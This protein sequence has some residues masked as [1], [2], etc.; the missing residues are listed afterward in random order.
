MRT[1][2]GRP[3]AR[4]STP[5]SRPPRSAIHAYDAW[6]GSIARPGPGDATLIIWDS[7]QSN[8]PTRTVHLDHLGDFTTTLRVVPIAGLAVC[9]GVF[10]AFVAAALLKLIGL[11]TNVFFFQRLDTSLVSPTG[12]HLGP[13]VVL[14]PVAG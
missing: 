7:M 14:V 11:F 10:A 8:A 6:G 5:P 12:H 1:A 9:I 4:A 2:A 3:H 13:F